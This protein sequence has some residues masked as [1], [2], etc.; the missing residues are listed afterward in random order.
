MRFVFWKTPY[1]LDAIRT[2]I[3]DT[4]GAYLAFPNPAFYIG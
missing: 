3:E 4:S 1:A 2:G